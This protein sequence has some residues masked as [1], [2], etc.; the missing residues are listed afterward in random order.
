[1]ILR[2]N[3]KVRKKVRKIIANLKM[4]CDARGIARPLNIDIGGFAGSLMPWNL[5]GMFDRRTS[6]SPKWAVAMLGYAMLIRHYKKI[7]S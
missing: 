1:M 6:L 3:E 4:N 7:L 2:I 5:T